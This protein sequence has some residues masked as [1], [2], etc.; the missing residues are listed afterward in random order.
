MKIWLSR[1]RVKYIYQQ[2]ISHFTVI[3]IPII[4][5]SLI[6]AHYIENFIYENK[7]N[8]LISY[9]EKIVFDIN[10]SRDTT[11]VLNSYQTVLASQK[12]EYNIFNEDRQIIYPTGG[13]ITINDDD[14]D[15]IRNGETVA[16]KRDFKRFQ[17]EGGVTF[18]LMPVFQNHT[19]IG[20][21][22]LTSPI[23]DSSQMISQINKYLF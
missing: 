17:S 15:R 3:F 19:F 5:L 10:R 4:V 13:R 16:V 6:F 11:Y 2:F 1:M 14:W 22:L 7:V 18:V 20:G 23:S 8:E 21:V 12:I 9:G